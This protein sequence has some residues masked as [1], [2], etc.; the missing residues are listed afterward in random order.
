[1]TLSDGPYGPTT[2]EDAPTEYDPEDIE[3]A[4]VGN[5]GEPASPGGETEVDVSGTYLGEPDPPHMPNG[6]PADFTV[7]ENKIPVTR[8]PLRVRRWAQS[9]GPHPKSAT[10]IR[11]ATS[12]R[13]A[14][15]SAERSRKS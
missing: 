7:E 10:L 4:L 1:V 6:V 14:I 8:S 11:R 9:P 12:K 5:G 13:D 2:D 3:A 15:Q